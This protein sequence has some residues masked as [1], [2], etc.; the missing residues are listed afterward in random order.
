MLTGHRI[1]N[2]NL[3]IHRVWLVYILRFTLTNSSRGVAVFV[4]L[5]SLCS[6]F[7][8]LIEYQRHLSVVYESVLAISS[9]WARSQKQ[10]G[11]I[12]FNMLYQCQQSRAVNGWLMNDNVTRYGWHL[13]VYGWLELISIWV[14]QYVNWGWLLMDGC[15]MIMLPYGTRFLHVIIILWLSFWFIDGASGSPLK[16]S[17]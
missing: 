9:V 5:F 16:S 6:K 7:Q 3:H 15:W 14:N 4:L 12:S 17:A 13:S 2:D 11:I 8:H 10:R 1:Y